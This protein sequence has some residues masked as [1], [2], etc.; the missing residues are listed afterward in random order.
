MG[1]RLG[2]D[3]GAT[4]VVAAVADDTGAV[5]AVPLGREAA[6]P[7]AVLVDTNGAIRCGD[8]AAAAAAKLPDRMV[9]R[10]VPRI[11]DEIPMTVGPANGRHTMLLP[12]DIT[13]AVVAWVIAKSAA[14]ERA[15][16]D[17]VTLVHPAGWGAHKLELMQRALS[18]R[19]LAHVRLVSGA[20]AA[21][22]AWIRVTGAGPGAAFAVFDLGGESVVASALRVGDDGAAWPLG[23]PSGRHDLGG[24]DFDD[25]VL[26]HVLGGLEP[27]A[28]QSL[29]EVRADSP[30]LEQL[31]LACRQAKET[32][33]SATDATIEVPLDGRRITTRIT[34][35]EFESAVADVAQRSIDLLLDAVG[36]AGLRVGDLAGVLLCGGTSAVPFIA[37]QLTTR[38]GPTAR[39]MREIHPAFTAAAGAA[40]LAGAAPA[41]PQPAPAGKKRPQLEVPTVVG[42]KPAVIEATAAEPTDGADRWGSIRIAPMRKGGEPIVPAAAKATGKQHA[43]AQ[44]AA[45]AHQRAAAQAEQE[46]AVAQAAEAAREAMAARATEAAHTA[47]DVAAA[48]RTAEADAAERARL[49]AERAVAERVAERAE[50]EHARLAAEIA[51]LTEENA[52]LVA[53][54]AAAE[55]A[56]A[57]QIAAAE[58]AATQKA[59]AAAKAAVRRAATERARLAEENTRQAQ[60]HAIAERAAAERAATEQANAKRAAALQTAAEKAATERAAAQQAA[61]TQAAAERAAAEEQRA[62]AARAERERIARERIAREHAEREQAARSRPEAPT[63][64]IPAAR[65]PEADVEFPPVYEEPPVV[66]SIPDLPGPEARPNRRRSHA[67]A[68][69]AGA[70]SAR[71]VVAPRELGSLEDLLAA[72]TPHRLP[73]AASSV[74]APADQDESAM[75]TTL[76]IVAGTQVEELYEYTEGEFWIDE[77]GQIVDAEGNVYEW[78][79]AETESE[80]QDAWRRGL[81]V[82]K[83]RRVLALMA[84]TAALV[85]GSGAWRAVDPGL[86]G[87]GSDSSGSPSVTQ[88]TPANNT[89]TTSTATKS[90]SSTKAKKPT[91]TARGSAPTQANVL[92]DLTP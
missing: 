65:R 87:G 37:Q 83:P 68:V 25:A 58:K 27:T 89:P 32:L 8:E 14:N 76:E 23:A 84:I 18:G 51:R 70:V 1:Y 21:G 3:L 85:V 15:M 33:S 81:G 41:A 38:L 39:L 64:P 31:R 82:V 13:A 11:G 30:V 9:R 44:H 50:I 12:Q 53:E 55:Q 88:S 78:A 90:T 10:F 92:T 69:V 72:P 54:N 59:L 91:R 79:D 75:E 20:V 22:Q 57:E 24:V 4:V 17:A 47:E 77:D 74:E 86:L 80:P 16:P 43:Q 6:V 7:A 5:R 28:T 48:Q 40:L 62:A 67:G 56:A 46:L 34:R 26:R 2:I 36:S 73:A 52:R 66:S 45:I 29:A 19:G 71:S 61:A 35:A 42:R 63:T 49:E 60:E